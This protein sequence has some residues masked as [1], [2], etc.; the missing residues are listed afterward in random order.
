VPDLH[1]SFIKKAQERAEQTVAELKRRYD[2]R[3]VQ[4]RDTAES[5]EEEALEA[6]FEV[7]IASD[8]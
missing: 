1:R 6:A 5:R 8:A 4:L 7:L 2:E 3:H